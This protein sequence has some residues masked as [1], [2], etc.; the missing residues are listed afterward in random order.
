MFQ[1]IL[2]RPV[3]ATV[4]SIF[5]TIAGVLGLVSL[6]IT[7]YPEIAPPIVQISA[8]YPGANA[9]TVLKSVIAPLEEEINGVEKMTYVVS[10]A[11]NDGSATIKVYFETGTDADMASVNVQNRVA[12]ASNKLPV[13]VNNYG[14][15]TLKMQ[16]N[17]L[18]LMSIYSDNPDYDQTFI[19]NYTRINIYPEIQRI[20]GVGSVSIF[21]AGDYSMRI[22]LN[23]D[24][25]A[26][27]N[28][29]PND[30]IAAI[31]EQNIE[32]APGKFG[33]QSNAPFEYT[34]KYKGKFDDVSEYENIVIKAFP[35]GRILKLKDVA[36]IELGAFSYAVKTTA[37]DNPA[38]AMAIYQMAGSNAKEVVDNINKTLK[39]MEKKFPAGV[40]WI[41]PYNTNKFLDASI[42]EV[43]KTLIEAFILVFIV[44][45]IFLQDLKS[46]IIP[47]ISAVV[48]LVGTL[49]F[50]MAFGFTINLLTL[51]ALVLA[52]GIVVDDAIV[53][54]EA[55]HAK[56]S[57]GE[58]STEKATKSAMNEIS[59]AIISISL[60]MSAVF[61]PVSFM[62]GP[63]G[64]FYTQFAITLACAVIL[65]AINALTLSPILCIM[66]IKHKEVEEG[67]KVSFIQKCKDGFNTAFDS[68]TNKYVAI[69]T[70]FSKRLIIPV[71]I[72]IAFAL[73]AIF[74]ISKTPSTFIP[75]E[76]QGILLADISMP[77][78]TSL[79]RTNQVLDEVNKICSENEMITGRIALSGTSLMSGV[80]GGNYAMMV[81]GLKN[82]DD[83]PNVSINDVIGDLM[84]KTAH[85]NDGSIRFFYP[86]TVPGFGIA[87]GFEMQLQDKTGGDLAKFNEV[88][89]NFIGELFKRP[90]IKY[91][92]SVFDV[93]YPQYEFN[94]NVDKCK[95]AG[96]AVSDVF[97]ALQAYYG[98]YI[99]SDFNR[100]T[101][102]YRVVVQ[103]E[104]NKRSSLESINAIQVR[105]AKGQMVPISTLINFKRIFGP[106][107][108]TRFNLFTATTISGEPN[109]GY[110]TGDAIA[111][112]QEVGENLPTG[113][114]F[115]FSGMTREEIIS[116][117]QSAI[118]FA[119]CFIFVF[120]ILAAQYE[121]YILP[122]SVLLPL[123]IGVCGVFIFIYP[124]GLGNSIYVQ[125]A[126]IM[127]IGLLAKN[128]ILIVEFAKQRREHGLSIKEAAI[129]GA[130]ARLRPILMTSFAFIGGMIPLVL[131]DG[132]G[133]IGNKSI[134]IA[135]AGGMLIGTLFG[136]LIIPSMFIIFRTLDEKLKGGNTHEA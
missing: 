20:D 34:I 35:D 107:S 39:Q 3:L 73:G 94:V 38:V 74:L 87:S 24:K 122:L 76:D 116:G 50:L 85:I 92:Y 83:R 7:Q 103:A 112:I 62:G 31:Q 120:L 126:L 8:T 99:A 30:V 96:V 11:G 51:F 105:N 6:P 29:I 109:P 82:W 133:A 95:L 15:T 98:S 86:P 102:F 65:S 123:F 72:L 67:T 14:I 26:S 124:S 70:K 80:N 58:H 27:L 136:V 134:G 53:V 93:N 60:V 63:S 1:K 47:S 106:Q 113:Y 13:A 36:K 42:H 48:A 9:E 100:F 52:I 91:A 25:L 56:L 12:S 43:L 33:E 78:G 22:W 101:K 41:A 75:N 4:I 49:F 55:V 84:Q 81:M 18:L 54:V 23:P 61:I 110:T 59:G 135:A 21:G 97:S 89:N 46:T 127:L 108:L 104:P 28:L 44:I 16:N 71:V 114:D 125:V 130:K 19:E 132:A 5:I 118:I 2:D 32:A 77:A 119:L 111:A 117:G 69:L 115:A 128:G 88:Q 45:L 40:K 68:L 17:I 37:Q 64:V 90:E 121:S 79:A 10:T 131:A 129:E 57:G 66:L